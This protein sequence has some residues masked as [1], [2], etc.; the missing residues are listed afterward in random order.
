MI[1][2]PE[3]YIHN[4]Q[5]I[6]INK[7]KNNNF[8]LI[9]VDI[10]NTLIPCDSKIVSDDAINFVNKL[11]DN[12]KVVVASNNVSKRVKPLADKLGLPY[13]SFALKP[14][15]FTFYRISKDYKV[16]RNNMVLIGDQIMTDVL[17]TK[18]SNI[19]CILVDPIV[20]KDNIFGTITRSIEKIIRKICKFNKGD[21]YDKM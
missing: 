2:K 5:Q 6:D 3:T 15:P 21:Y 12:F 1:F 13:Y 16:K 11:K 8:K 19:S 18:T 4:Y 20:D 17:A 7:L 9:I 14:L 10:D